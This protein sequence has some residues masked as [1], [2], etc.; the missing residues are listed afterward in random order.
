[1]MTA[2]MMNVSAS[3]MG[4][5]KAAVQPEKAGKQKG[6]PYAEDNFAKQRNQG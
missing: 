1:M 3:A 4:R 2:A 5:N 6:E